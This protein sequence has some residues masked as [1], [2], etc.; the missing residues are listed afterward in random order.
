MPVKVYDGTNW[1]TV[2]GDGAQGP[3]GADGS[4]PLTTKGD[5]LGYSTTPARLAVGANNTVLTADSA[6]ATGLKWAVPAGAANFTLL[7]SGG[8]SLSG[9]TTTISGISGMDKIMVL[10]SGA[11]STNVGATL[12][13]RLNTDTGANYYN[14]GAQLEFGSTYSNSIGQVT[15]NFAET[16]VNVGKMSTNAGSV[17]TGYVFINGCN[18]S[19]QKMFQGIGATNTS[20][21]SD[22]IHS[23]VGGYYSSSSTIS[24]ISLRLNT[25]TFDAGTVFVYASA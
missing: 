6:E 23:Y 8:T 1:V 14:Y 5:L 24:S 11:S 19:G 16:G 15:G 18:T 13:L 17:A 3:A 2:A 4:A 21:G 9:S 25:G 22:Q 12:Q 20:S 10:I 7:N